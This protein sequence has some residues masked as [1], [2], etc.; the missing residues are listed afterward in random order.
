[1]KKIAEK[2]VDLIILDISDRQGL[3]NEWDE[4]DEFQDEIKAGWVTITENY[5]K[6]YGQLPS[7]VSRMRAAQLERAHRLVSDIVENMLTRGGLENAWEDCDEEIQIEIFD[8]WV[9]IVTDNWVK[10]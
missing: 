1:M 5:L 6:S 2:I 3:G 7:T 9:E 4:C 10:D 8:E